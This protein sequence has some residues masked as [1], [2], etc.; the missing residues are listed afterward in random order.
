MIV[1]QA[2]RSVIAPFPCSHNQLCNS[3]TFAKQPDCTCI[4]L[5]ILTQR[6]IQDFFR[7]GPTRRAPRKVTRRALRG[8]NQKISRALP[9]PLR[10]GPTSPLA[11]PRPYSTEAL[12]GKIKNS[13]APP[14]RPL[15]GGARAL[16]ASPL[17]PPLYLP[18]PYSFLSSLASS[19]RIRARFITQTTSASRG[20]RLE[21]AKTKTQTL[22]PKPSPF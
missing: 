2:A 9:R 11:P 18:L 12:H 15:R 13:L 5:S 21:Q 3:Q 14:P 22:R 4:F 20:F 8:A 10:G 7:G 16:K 1:P 17:D 19:H 6:R